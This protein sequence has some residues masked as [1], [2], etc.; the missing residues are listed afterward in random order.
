M[1]GGLMQLVAYGTR[2]ISYRYPQI[3]FFKASTADTLTF[4]WKLLNKHSTVPQI[5][6]RK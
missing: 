4:Q 1:G 3:T 2:Y 6:A 5:S